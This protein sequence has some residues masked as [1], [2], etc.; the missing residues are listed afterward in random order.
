MSKNLKQNEK[1]C[2]EKENK[3]IRK[4]ALA[5]GWDESNSRRKFVSKKS[6]D[7]DVSLFLLQNDKLCGKEDVISFANLTHQRAGIL[8]KGDNI[9]GRGD[10]DDEEILLDL[11]SI[12]DE[13]NKLVCVV[14]IYQAKERKQHFGMIKNA[15]CRLIDLENNEEICRFELNEDYTQ[16][17]AM[18]V[19]ELY[20]QGQMWYFHPVAQPTRDESITML[21]Q[22]YI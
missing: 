19:G 18:I 15:Y 2:L 10:G 1:I 5:L 8:H 20:K 22:R 3:P 14:N 16:M 7:C 11:K 4:I 13:Y 12:P 17:Y 21:M 6:I 9:N